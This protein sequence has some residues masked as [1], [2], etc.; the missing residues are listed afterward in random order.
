MNDAEQNY[1]VTE[2]ECLTIIWAIK[3]FHYFLYKNEF[4][5]VTY[6]KKI[7]WLKNHK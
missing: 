6:H 3:Y 7:P 1:T 4:T 2:K 5:I